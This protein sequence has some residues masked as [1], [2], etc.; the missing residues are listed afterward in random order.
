MTKDAAPGPRGAS[1]AAPAA[2]C[3]VAPP[4]SRPAAIAPA[5]LA[6]PLASARK[7]DIHRTLQALRHLID[8]SE[9]SRREIEKRL[10]ARG[11]GVSLTRLLAGRYEIKLRHLPR[12]SA[13]T[14]SSSSV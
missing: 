13:S 9:L 4:A 11:A 7:A 6:A 10:A 3:A 5:G 8:L 14:R 12:S 2:S 1:P